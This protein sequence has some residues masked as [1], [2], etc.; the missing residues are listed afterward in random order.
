[1][2]IEDDQNVERGKFSEDEIATSSIL[3]GFTIK[4]SK[5]L[6]PENPR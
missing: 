6:D 2:N 3:D 4:V 1:M 5:A